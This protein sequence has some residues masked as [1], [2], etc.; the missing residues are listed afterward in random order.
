MARFT[1]RVELHGV[2]TEAEYKS[3]HDDMFAAGFTRFVTASDGTNYLL[4]S[5]EYD[6]ASSAGTA[7]Q[8]RDRV[9]II[10]ARHQPVFTPKRAAWVLVTSGDAAWSLDPLQT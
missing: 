10:A 2:K 8:V 3:L 1:V 7:A 9:V 4:P 5:A 6:L